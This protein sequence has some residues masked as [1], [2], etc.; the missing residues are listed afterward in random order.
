M[1][2]VEI[3]AKKRTVMEKGRAIRTHLKAG[4][5]RSEILA[6]EGF[7]VKEYRYAIKKLSDFPSKNIEAF[8]SFLLDS[9]IAIE[10]LAEDSERVR[11]S[12]DYRALVAFARLAH[13]IRVST[14][15]LATKLGFLQKA[16]EQI[17]VKMDSFEVSFGDEDV[18][19]IWPTQ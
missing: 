4:R 11:K 17:E 8:S 3:L 14:M 10:Q 2:E 15:D 16:A 6:I 19:P 18:K 5:S 13:D 7:T 9:Q 1:A 12:G